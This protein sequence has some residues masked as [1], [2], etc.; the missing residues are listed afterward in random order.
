MVSED[1]KPAPDNLARIVESAQRLGVEIDEAEALQWLA[2]MAAGQGAADV[3]VDVHSGVFGHKISM[4]DFSP[5]EL[6]YF[7]RIGRI[8]QIDDR[9]GTVETA[10]ALSGSAA[11]SKIQ[12]Y[13]GDCDF[14]ERVNIHAGSREEACALLATVMKEKALSTERGPNYQLMEVA[15]GSFPFG[16]VR[17]GK[18][19]RHGDPISWTPK[20][21]K[22]GQIEVA[23]PDGT[24][25]TLQWYD[26]ADAPG[27]CKLDWIVADPVRGKLSNASNM[28]DATWE[29]P[30]GSITPLDGHLDAYFQ[31]IY[32]EAEA[33]PIFS[34]LARHVSADALD[35]YVAQLEKEVRKYLGKEANYGKAAKRMYN[36]FRLTGRYLEAAYIRELFD[37]PATVLYQ[38][39]SLLRT[40]DEACQ[41]DSGI[42]MESVIAQADSLVLSVVQ[43]L[44]GEQESEIVKSLLHLRGTLVRQESGEGRGAEVEGARAQV[45]NIINTFFH[46]RL[47]SLPTIKEYMAGFSE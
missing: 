29:A 6:D 3:V 9:P 44:E 30:D 47:N 5:Q 24:P 2:A 25:S 34:K 27:W 28:L 14:F 10:L 17:R 37:E 32:L 11:Q 43:A 8:V 21:I 40:L 45:I 18:S 15:F 26:V 13:P 31:E 46:E 23:L 22:A 33:I 35:N 42:E 19:K 16:C 7:R 20:E 36:V 41:P 1:E 4:L 12:T 38:V 39:W